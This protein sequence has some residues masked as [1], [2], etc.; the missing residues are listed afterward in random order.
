MQFN[1]QLKLSVNVSAKQFHQTNFVQQIE[2]TI[3]RYRVN[4]SLLNLE[5]TES[6]LIGD[7]EGTIACMNQFKKLGVNFELDDSHK[8]Y[9]DVLDVMGR[10]VNKIAEA[11]LAAGEYQFELPADLA[12]G[13]Y[14]VRI[15]IDGRSTSRKVMVNR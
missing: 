3:S 4:P 14:N 12:S 9:I 5:L 10:T 11:T 13:L 6:M 8:V 15:F 7:T 1:N 2:S